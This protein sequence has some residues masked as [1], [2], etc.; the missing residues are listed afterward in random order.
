VS[1]PSPPTTNSY[2]ITSPAETTAG[3][4]AGGGIAIPVFGHHLRA[5]IRFSHWFTGA[6]DYPIALERSGDFS[7]LPTLF[8]VAVNG[9]VLSAPASGGV[10]Q[11]A[12]EANLL[13]GFS[14]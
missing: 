9:Y 12:N 13:L 11:R 8:P 4:T 1:P 14:F 10:A 7:V 3:I 5:E 6:N 2:T